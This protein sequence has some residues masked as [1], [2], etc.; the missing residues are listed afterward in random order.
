MWSGSAL[1]Y[2][3]FLPASRRGEITQAGISSLSIVEHLDVL[4]DVRYGFLPGTILLKMNQLLLSLPK[5]LSI[6][7]LSQQFPLQSVTDRPPEETLPLCRYF[8][9]QL[10]SVCSE[11]LKR[12]LASATVSPPFSTRLAASSL[13]SCV[14]NCLGIRSNGHLLE[15]RR[16][17]DWCP[18]FP[19]FLT[20]MLSGW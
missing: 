6:D 3:V 14:L 16:L 17:S 7:A 12:L 4:P 11:T 10:C 2:G 1:L 5:K 19:A 9:I 13:N 18:L 15:P 8:L 20:L